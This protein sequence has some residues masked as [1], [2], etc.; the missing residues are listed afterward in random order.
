[1]KFT[2]YETQ[3]TLQLIGDDHVNSHFTDDSKRQV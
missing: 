2:T 3:H 1:M